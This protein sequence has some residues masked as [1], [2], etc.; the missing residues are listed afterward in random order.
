MSGCFYSQSLSRCRF[1]PR[2]T[3]P[4]RRTLPAED[5]AAGEPLSDD[6]SIR[7][8]DFYFLI[9]STNGEGSAI[10]QGASRSRRCRLHFYEIKISLRSLP[11][12]G[13]GLLDLTEIYQSSPSKPCAFDFR[14]PTF[15]YPRANHTPAAP[16]L[17]TWILVLFTNSCCCRCVR[18]TS[19][20]VDC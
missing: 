17:R 13:R 3:L 8:W 2:R 7:L 10:F 5:T 18:S 20:A 15:A 16:A 14:R 9:P 6:D 11:I 19:E 4:S 1:C 12:G